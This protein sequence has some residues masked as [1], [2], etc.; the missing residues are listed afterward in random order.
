[1]VEDSVRRLVAS[2]AG[3]L[4]AHLQTRLVS[5]AKDVSN[6]SSN[7]LVAADNGGFVV[8][9]CFVFSVIVLNFGYHAQEWVLSYG[10]C[11]AMNLVLELGK[12]PSNSCV[13]YESLP[14]RGGTTATPRFA[15]NSPFNDVKPME[16]HLQIFTVASR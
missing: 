13:W 2:C 8:R 15:I 14:I 9:T 5:D 1:M 6:T 10:F 16:I 11:L 12:S 7:H 3:D 4:L